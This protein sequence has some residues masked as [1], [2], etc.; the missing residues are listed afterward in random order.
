MSQS[1][2]F[3]KTYDLM[4]WLIPR[5]LDFPKRQRGVLAR[6]VQQELFTFYGALVDAAKSKD[7]LTHLRRADAALVKLRTCLRL[8]EELQL[9]STRQ[10]GHACRLIKPVG[11]LL[12]GWLNP[13]LEKRKTA[14]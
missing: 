2:L 13:L 9:L 12:G 4:A 1:P 8:C 11:N 5:T 7:P 10:Y 3:I 14:G 6:Q